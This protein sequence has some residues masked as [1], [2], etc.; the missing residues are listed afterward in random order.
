LKANPAA[1]RPGGARLL[2]PILIGL[3]VMVVAGLVGV[4]LAWS[5]AAGTDLV[6]NQ[7]PALVASLVGLALAGL[8][9]VAYDVDLGRRQDAVEEEAWDAVI[10][11]VADL[12]RRVDWW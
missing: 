12:A 1:D 8:G 4:G 10:E 9:L 7:V 2:N 11:G 6:P 5:R 3:A